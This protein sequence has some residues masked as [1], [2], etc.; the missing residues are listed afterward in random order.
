MR[1]QGW[2]PKRTIRLALWDGEE[3]GLVGSTEWVE[4]HQEELERKA[5]VYINS[6][7]NGRGTIYAG[8][9]HTLQTFMREVLRD[10]NDP[11]TQKSLL[12]GG[13]KESAP[14]FRLGALGSGSDYVGFLHHAGI[15][16]LNLG[17]G[18]AD[19]GGVYHSVYDTLDWFRR[20]SDGEMVYGKSLAQVMITTLLRLVDAPVLP[21]E[22][23]TLSR[24]VH[25][26]L[27][28]IQKEAAK[29]GGA[30][31]IRDVQAQLTR[32][33]AASQAYDAELGALM[34]RVSSVAP[35]KLTKV[36]E[37]LAHAERTLLLTDGLP[38]RE[39]YR[40]QIYAPGL[41]TGYGVKTLPGI[42]EAEDAKRWDEANQQA[43]RVALA[44]R[45]MCAQVEEA[46]RLL[47]LAG[48]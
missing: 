34:K 4:K 19:A 14:G 31:D 37:A 42:R 13:H 20:F 32:L 27:E 10:L 23:H 30:V 26:Y 25:G 47:K 15:A 8:G 6:D 1:K 28:D 43:R 35:E 7:S 38:H 48:D 40:H 11:V 41:Y 18:G 2:Q 9:S 21:F 17:F 24:T 3:F 33:H 46:T 36:N 45:A 5:A 29:N 44:L 12:D 39:W 22:F 16:S